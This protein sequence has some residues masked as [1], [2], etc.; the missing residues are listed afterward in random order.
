MCPPIQCHWPK[1]P[2][3]KSLS[4]E[5]MTTTLQNPPESRIPVQQYLEPTEKLSVNRSGESQ[6]LWIKAGYDY[7]FWNKE[8]VYTPAISVLVVERV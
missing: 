5:L 1:A 6:V 2:T 7:F 4:S 8:V 3:D